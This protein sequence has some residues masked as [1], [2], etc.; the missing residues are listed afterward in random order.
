L[1]LVV[2]PPDPAHPIIIG[3]TT[4]T[5]T[6]EFGGDPALSPSEHIELGENFHITVTWADKTVSTLPDSVVV[7]AGD[8]VD[9]TSDSSGTQTWTVIAGSGTGPVHFN[10]QHTYSVVYLISAGAHVASMVTVSS[11]PTFVLSDGRVTGVSGPNSLTSSQGSL[12]TPV[13]GNQFQ[14]A[15]QPV[16]VVNSIAVGVIL[17]PAVQPPAQINTP[18]EAQT[19]DNPPPTGEQT[20]EGARQLI[21]VRV[22]ADGS[23]S[24]P[25]VLPD[26]ALERLN[27]LFEKFKRMHLPNGHYRIYLEEPGFSKRQL[28][29]FYKSGDTIGDPVHEPGPGSQK[30]QETSPAPQSGGTTRQHGASPADHVKQQAAAVRPSVSTDSANRQKHVAHLSANANGSPA[31]HD[32]TLHTIGRLKY[33]LAAAAVAAINTSQRLKAQRRPDGPEKSVRR[34]GLLARLRRAGGRK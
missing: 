5:I 11:D 27:D 31:N 17:P 2:N 15:Q 22:A 20:D 8:T 4:Q 9:L 13:A 23:E 28:R 12:Q 24:E 7:N 25:H 18:P 32:T 21:L 6:G 29:E 19:V 1:P 14:A 16:A 30:L 3:N 34:L 33:P 26:D 10:L